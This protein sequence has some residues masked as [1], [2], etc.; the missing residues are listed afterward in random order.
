[1]NTTIVTEEVRQFFDAQSCSWDSRTS[2]DPDLL[3]S[4][5]AWLPLQPDDSVLDVG[6]GTGVLLPYIRERVPQGII[7][8]VDLSPGMLAVA[9]QKYGADPLMHF[10]P[11]DITRDPLPHRYRAIILYSVF[12]HLY[13]RDETVAHLV[14]HNLLPGGFLLIA[15]TEGRKWLNEMHRNRLAPS[16]RR[17]LFPAL[18]QAR[19]FRRMGLHVVYAAESAVTYFILLT[20]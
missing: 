4:L 9:K 18:V 17:D 5:L 14:A 1:M 20:R 16:M 6:T 7:D 15:H 8:A 12:P 11:A 3:R 19:R 13:R 10:I 2:R